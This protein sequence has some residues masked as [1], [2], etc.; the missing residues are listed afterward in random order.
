V[1]LL[2]PGGEAVGFELDVCLRRPD[3]SVSCANDAPAVHG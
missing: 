2:D 1:S 3:S